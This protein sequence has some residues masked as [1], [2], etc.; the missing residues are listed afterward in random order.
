MLSMMFTPMVTLFGL[1]IAE[2]LRMPFGPNLEPV[3]KE[4]AV[5]N[6]IPM[7]AKSRPSADS[8]FGSLMKFP[9][10]QNLGELVALGG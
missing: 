4:D 10:L 8:A 5:S 6:G 7:I 3:R 2:I 9:M 1:I